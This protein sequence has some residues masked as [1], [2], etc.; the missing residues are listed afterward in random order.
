MRKISFERSKGFTLVELMVVIAIIGILAV[1][2]LGIVRGAQQKAVNAAVQ[3]SASNLSTAVETY[4]TQ[5]GHY[6][7]TAGLMT[8]LVDTAKVI[9]R[10][11][12]LP[13]QCNDGDI[14]TAALTATD[15]GVCGIQYTQGSTSQSYTI[16]V[17][18]LGKGALEEPITGGQ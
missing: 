6:P 4:Y 14:Q 13:T 16:N 17:K 10:P 11:I 3:A 8:E 9:N 15:T 5:E 18:L 1:A 7:S 12:T 2:A